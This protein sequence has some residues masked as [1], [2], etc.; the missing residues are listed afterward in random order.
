MLSGKAG[1]HWPEYSHLNC[2]RISIYINE[3]WEGS[4]I[5]LYQ[6]RKI[7]L[8][9]TDV[10]VEWLVEFCSLGF[11]VQVFKKTYKS[12][13]M[14]KAWMCRMTSTQLYFNT[15]SAFVI[16]RYAQSKPC[17]FMCPEKGKNFWEARHPKDGWSALSK[18]QS[19]LWWF[20]LGTS[21]LKYFYIYFLKKDLFKFS[22]L[23][24]KPTTPWD[25]G[26]Y[27]EWMLGHKV[28]Q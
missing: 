20:K 5:K 11:K 16:V 8:F 2:I 19:Y 22:F 18:K 12:I 9:C 6:H 17:L 4:V 23:Y 25:K 28:W 13:S 10:K 3:K 14:H 27:T 21:T 24:V 15:R 1:T 26:T 7:E